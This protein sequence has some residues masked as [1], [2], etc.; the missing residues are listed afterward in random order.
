M[1]DKIVTLKLGAD[2]VGQVLD[3]LCVRRDDWRY[4][5]RY[6]EDGYEEAGRLILECSDGD[7]ARGLA[8][9][10]DRIIGEIRGQ[11]GDISF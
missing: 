8:D 9:R 10:Y 6:F 2:D 4:T 3:C 7:E 1:D 5:Q 11:M